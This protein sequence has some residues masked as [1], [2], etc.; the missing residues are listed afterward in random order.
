MLLKKYI[1]LYKVID[2]MGLFYMEHSVVNMRYYKYLSYYEKSTCT[3]NFSPLYLKLKK[4]HQLLG[5]LI[6]NN[7]IF[8]FIDLDER[9]DFFFNM[10]HKVVIYIKVY[11]MYD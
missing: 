5:L 1:Y 2:F 8:L 6:K 3:I 9:L 10:L 7:N 4:L 11:F